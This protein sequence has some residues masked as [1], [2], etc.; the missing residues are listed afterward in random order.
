MK[1]FTAGDAEVRREEID[2]LLM[3]LKVLQNQ[4]AT[5]QTLFNLCAPL[6]PLRGKVFSRFY[7]TLG[8]G[9][10]PK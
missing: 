4:N 7:V 9:N 10:M 3:G 1:E 6:R 5:W 2:L 8:Y